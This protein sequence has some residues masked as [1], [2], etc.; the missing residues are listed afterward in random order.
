MQHVSVGARILWRDRMDVE[1]GY[2][3]MVLH[4]FHVGPPPRPRVYVEPF[5]PDLAPESIP[6]AKPRAISYLSDAPP[7]LRSPT[8]RVLSR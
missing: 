1:G 8:S 4:R 7:T 2:L 3:Q 6:I 5:S